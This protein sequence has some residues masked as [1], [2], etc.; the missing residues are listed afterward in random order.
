VTGLGARIPFDVWRHRCRQA[1]TIGGEHFFAPRHGGRAPR[2]ALPGR[3]GDALVEQ[4]AS[5]RASQ[6]YHFAAGLRQ[7]SAKTAADRAG[8]ANQNAHVVLACE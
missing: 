8:A 7:P 4:L 3:D 1:R 6:E 2:I 5:P